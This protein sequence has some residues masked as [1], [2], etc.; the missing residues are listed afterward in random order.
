MAFGEQILNMLGRK[1]PRLAL[2]AMQAGGASGTPQAGGDT[3]GGAAPAPATDGG[4]APQQP[5]AYTSPPELMELYTQLMDRQR[6]AQLIDRGIGMIGASLAHPENR[7]GIMQAFGGGGGSSG[8]AQDPMSL[9][10]GIMEMQQQQSALAQKAAHRAALPAIAAQ[11]GLDLQ[12]VQYLFDTGKLDALLSDLSKPDNQIVQGSDGRY[13]IVD[14]RTGSISEGLGPE[15]PRDIEIITDDRGNQFPIYKDTGQRVGD[16]NIVEGQGATSDERLWRADEEDRAARGL[17]S[18]PL[19]QFIQETGRA[20]AGAANLG[21][22]GVDYGAPDDGYVWKRTPDGSVEVTEDGRP[23]QVPK[24][25]GKVEEAQRLKAIE[26]EELAKSIDAH[27]SLKDLSTTFVDFSAR[28]ALNL[29]K[30]GQSSWVTDNGIFRSAAQFMPSTDAYELEKSLFT[31]RSTFG[32]EK[33]NMIRADPDNKTGGALGQVSDFENRMLQ[34]TFGVLD[35]G[36]STPTLVRNIFRANAMASAIM[37]RGLKA[38]GMDLKDPNGTRV[39]PE[40]VLEA[41]DRAAEEF[42]HGTGAKPK[43]E[44]PSAGTSAPSGSVPIEDIMR[45]YGG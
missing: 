11:Y 42:I 25:G 41:A 19:S 12:T 1:D 23:V 16:Q 20:R 13:Y 14:K 6:S 30:K 36:L 39:T 5:Q 38:P 10:T 29:I 40:E 45:R 18:R 2:L 44:A 17:P 9:I 34:S 35:V 37:S 3:S 4:Q 28:D 43:E 31:L 8:G 24:A 26:A 15:K 7:A 21:A 32:L 22:T 33:L 27:Q